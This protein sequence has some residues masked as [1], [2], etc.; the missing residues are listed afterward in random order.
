MRSITKMASLQHYH[1]SLVIKDLHHSL[2]I[3]GF[4]HSLLIK[5][6]QTFFQVKCLA[7]GLL[8]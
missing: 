8:L 4:H 2:A 7:P 5:D 3:K 1:H 6:F